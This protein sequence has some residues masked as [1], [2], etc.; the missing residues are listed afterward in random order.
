[1]IDWNKVERP[2]PEMV[3]PYDSLVQAPRGTHVVLDASFDFSLMIRCCCAGFVCKCCEIH[4]LFLR[5][6]LDRVWRCRYP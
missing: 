4:M 2:T 3:V 1:M 6:K 5:L